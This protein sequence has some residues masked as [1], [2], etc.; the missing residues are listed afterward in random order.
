MTPAE[1]KA[2]QPG[3]RVYWADP[4]FDLCSRWLI[5]KNVSTSEDGKLLSIDDT[6]GSHIECWCTELG[7]D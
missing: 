2:L 3:D 6:Y 5:I 1:A 7:Y 4:D